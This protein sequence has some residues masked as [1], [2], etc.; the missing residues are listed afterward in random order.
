VVLGAEEE[1]LL[2]LLLGPEPLIRV[3]L[4]GLEDCSVLLAPEAAAEAE[5]VKRALR[6]LRV[7]MVATVS[8]LP[9]LALLPTGPVV[10]AVLVKIK[11]EPEAKEVWVAGDLAELKGVVLVLRL[12]AFLT[13]EVE[14]GGA[15]VP[16][17][18]LQAVPVL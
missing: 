5:P 4:E 3:F 13:L 6:E 10:V 14:E 8:N 2:I 11:V 18:L 7:A 17:G 12:R 15:Q 9:L 1:T 16:G